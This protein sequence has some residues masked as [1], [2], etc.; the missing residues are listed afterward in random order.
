MSHFRRFIMACKIQDLPFCVIRKTS[1]WTTKRSK[2]STIVI[3][4]THHG[5][6]TIQAT[7]Q[8][9]TVAFKVLLHSPHHPFSF[10]LAMCPSKAIFNCYLQLEKDKENVDKQQ[11][12]TCAAKV[13]WGDHWHDFRS[14]INNSTEL[15]KPVLTALPVLGWALITKLI[16]PSNVAC[17]D[18]GVELRESHVFSL[19]CGFQSR[20]IGITKTHISLR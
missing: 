11:L 20:S 9:L 5:P 13:A 3:P 15:S 4:G 18:S 8:K 14:W 17:L 7:G 12:A 6:S 19:Q 16:C 10:L 1:Q 2:Y